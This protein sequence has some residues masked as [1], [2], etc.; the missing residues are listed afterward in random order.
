MRYQQYLLQGKKLYLT[1]CSNCHQNEGQGLV[2]LYPPLAKSDYLM[3][4]IPRA[5]CIIRNGLQGEIEVNGV[6]FNMKMEGHPELKP[7]EIAEILTYIS[8]SWG[9]EY[10]FVQVLDVQQHLRNCENY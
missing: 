6:G 2:A 10:G 8:N 7:L 4:N 1:H 9:N 5:A 3:E